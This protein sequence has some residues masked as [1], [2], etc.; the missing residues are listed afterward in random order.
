MEAT[1]TTMDRQEFFRLVGTSIGAILLS[2][3]LAGCNKANGTDPVPGETIDFTISLADNLFANLN[4][5]G[6][7][8]YKSG[9]IIARTQ[10]D[11]LIA[12][13]ATCTHESN[14]IIFQGANNRF[15]CP[16]HG[17]AFDTDGKVIVSP[18]TR[19][20]TKYNV[21]ADK[22]AGSIRVYS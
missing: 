22:T 19:A 21:L 10:A 7:Y 15:Y 2:Q 11:Q 5:K 9:I 3:C 18:A 8:A 4:Q 13:S 17:S 1:T 20:L 14:Q 6:G 12:V 16:S